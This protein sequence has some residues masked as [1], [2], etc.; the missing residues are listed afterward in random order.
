MS[1]VPARPGIRPRKA[2]HLSPPSLS[3]LHG[4]PRKL[5][6]NPRDRGDSSRTTRVQYDSRVRTVNGD[7]RAPFIAIQSLR[8]SHIAGGCGL[9]PRLFL[10]FHPPE[11]QRHHMLERELYLFQFEYRKNCKQDVRKCPW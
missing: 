3:S 8:N 1:Y 6:A 11:W 7:L 9:T 10:A 2:R 5:V 4:R